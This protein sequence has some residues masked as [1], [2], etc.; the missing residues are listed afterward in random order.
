MATGLLEEVCSQIGV[1][2][3]LGAQFVMRP[4]GVQLSAL[5]KSPQHELF[6][7]W[8]VSVSPLSRRELLGWLAAASVSAWRQACLIRTG[9]LST[10]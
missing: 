10:M 3:Q 8:S 6:Q 1:G 9:A 4:P 5:T 2:A 7:K